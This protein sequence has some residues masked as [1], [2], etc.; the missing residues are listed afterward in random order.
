MIGTVLQRYIFM[1]AVGSLALVI[2]IF[3]V[4]IMLVDVVEQLRTVGDNI[5]LS[6][7]MAVLLAALKLPSLIEE[8]FP[9]AIM[10]ASMMTYN[11]LNKTSELSVIRAMGQSAWQFLL[12]IIILSVMLGLFS[13]MVLNPIGAHLSNNFEATRSA[14]LEDGRARLE[15]V[16]EDIY[17]RE[18]TDDS[19]IFI[20]AESFDSTENVFTNVK[21]LEESRVYDG[22]RPTDEFRFRRRIDA[23]RARLIGGFWQL[24]DLVENDGVSRANPMER[25]AI[26]TD[27]DPNQLFNR[28]ISPDTIGFWSL[29]G[30]IS[31]TNYA[32]LDA[33]RFSMRFYG[34]TVLPVLFTAMSLIGALVCLRL[35][36]LGG[37][38]QLITAGALAAI[39]L[40][41]ITQLASSLGA[42]GAVPPMISAWAPALCAL[43]I[44]LA[45]IAYKEDG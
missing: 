31:Q 45:I 5:T 8:T 32:G 29:P 42:S 35:P 24:E 19:Q 6:P 23:A 28:F 44:A 3:V 16:Y 13:M 27:I 20:Y 4:T 21:L 12:P 11:Q 9:F 40:F 2:G 33:S 10:I 26:Q 22:A 25:L 1:R 43:F 41:F 36:R 30:F 15:A 14:L 7:L 17:H 18:G 38:S 37:T 39:A 34:L